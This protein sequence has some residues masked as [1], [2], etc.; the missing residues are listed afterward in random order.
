M[1]SKACTY[2]AIFSANFRALFACCSTA[3]WGPLTLVVGPRSH[4]PGA[5]TLKLDFS[6]R[7]AYA[8][9]DQHGRL[10]LSW[11]NSTLGKHSP[12]VSWQRISTDYGESWGPDYDMGL[13]ALG[14]TLLGPGEGIVLGRHDPRSKYK[15]RIV[16]CGAT[17]YVGNI[18][19]D[20]SMAVFTS[21][22]DGKTYQSARGTGHWPNAPGFP[23]GEVTMPFKGLAE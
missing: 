18:P 20:Q 9:V 17:G 21:D 12:K 13:G 14:S 22:D 3:A 8:T 4:V 1:R 11:V 19:G 2:N 15:G 7:N 5:S 10:L 16:I 6:A 23:T